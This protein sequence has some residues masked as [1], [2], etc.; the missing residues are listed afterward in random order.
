M[1]KYD[2]TN[3]Y[4]YPLVRDSKEELAATADVIRFYNNKTLDAISD[5]HDI[6]VIAIFSGQEELFKERAASWFDA[7]RYSRHEFAGNYAVYIKD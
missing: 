2:R 6:R 5:K 4:I 1:H 7:A 3:L